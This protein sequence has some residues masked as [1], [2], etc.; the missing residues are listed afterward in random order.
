MCRTDN[1]AAMESWNDLRTVLRAVGI[2]TVA[3]E[4]IYPAQC[5][6]GE[7]PLWDAGQERLYWT[8][9]SRRAIHWLE[10]GLS[11]C[12]TLTLERG[13]SKVLLSAEGGLVA[14]FANRVCHVLEDGTRGACLVECSDPEVERFNDGVIDARGRLWIGSFDK[15]SPIWQ[16]TDEPPLP[17]PQ[18]KLYVVDPDGDSRCFDLG[19]ELSNGI[20]I[21]PDGQ[22]LYQVDSHK[23]CIFVDRLDLESGTVS[24][25]QVLHAF[26][27]VVG[28][29]DG[30]AMDTDGCLWVAEIGAGQIVRITPDGQRDRSVGLP[31]SR[32][33]SVAFGGADLR[34]LFVTSM[35]LGLSEDQQK[36]EPMSGDIFAIEGLET[37]GLALPRYGQTA[38]R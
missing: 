33:T 23:A 16:G 8:D 35:K 34:T 7:G 25:R 9:V 3:V 14:A 12:Q 2:V 24:D 15:R 28:H 17:D 37:Q 26:G 11:D 27:D 36:A 6:M 30:M 5:Q 22:H 20:A 13:A 19:V 18:G 32:P 38:A 21:S 29:P 4:H 1:P 10:P 31:T